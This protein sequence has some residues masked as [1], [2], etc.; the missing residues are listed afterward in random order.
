[1]LDYDFRE[2]KVE[3]VIIEHS[4]QVSVSSRPF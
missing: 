4:R 3:P 1:L 2:V